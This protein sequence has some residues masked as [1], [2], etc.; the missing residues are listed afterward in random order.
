[1]IKSKFPRGHNKP[2]NTIFQLENNKIITSSDE[3]D[4]IIWDY[5]ETD[6]VYFIKGHNNIVTVICLIEGNKFV[7]VAKNNSLK[8]WE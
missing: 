7:S 3:N 6:S 5:I 2:I 8:I 1:M 4:I